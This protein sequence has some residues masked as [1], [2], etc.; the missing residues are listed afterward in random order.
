MAMRRFLKLFQRTPA[1]APRGEVAGANVGTWLQ[2][3]IGELPLDPHL[4]ARDAYTQTDETEA[5]KLYRETLRDERCMAALDQRLNASI[6]TPWEVEPASDDATDVAAAEDLAMQLEGLEF[7]RICRQL[8]HG[9]WYG[10]SVGEAMWGRDESRVTLANIVVRSLDRFWWSADGELLLRTWDRPEGERVPPGKFVVLTR[11][12]E[13]DDLPYAPGLAR[14]CYWPVWFKRHGMKFWAVALEKFGAPTAVGKYPKGAGEPE[15]DKLLAALTALASGAGLAIPEDQ[16]VELLETA[17]R[18]GGDYNTFIE[19]LDRSIT[20]TILGQASTTDQGAWKGT[21]EVQMEIR[22]E[23]IAADTRLLDAALNTTIVR[24][25][26]TWNFPTAGF[27]RIRHDAE[28]PEDLD[29]R[30][31]REKTI[32][33]TTGWRPT[34]EHVTDV[35]GG[36]WEEKPTPAP[37]GG[38]P[39]DPDGEGDD[40][41]LAGAADPPPAPPAR[42]VTPAARVHARWQRRRRVRTRSTR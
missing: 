15:K 25:L 3:Y 18:S 26:T 7:A 16:M 33:E 23:T 12:G 35:Y 4:R 32:S 6:S 11:P 42:R 38:P 20:K 5:L 41:T 13:H 10:W 29:R 39:D 2:P 1:T 36:E 37:P 24:W 8:L 28:P 22:D 17:Q 9:V 31:T 21:A 40:A 19:Y 34:M 14:W 27:P 30:A